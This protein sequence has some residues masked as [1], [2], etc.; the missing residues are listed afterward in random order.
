MFITGEALTQ[1]TTVWEKGLKPVSL[2]ENLISLFSVVF[3]HALEGERLEIISSVPDRDSIEWPNMLLN[4]VA[5]WM[6]WT[7][8][9]GSV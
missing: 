5:E 7:S 3:D 2:Y 8:T 4:F 9:E 1:A 6:K